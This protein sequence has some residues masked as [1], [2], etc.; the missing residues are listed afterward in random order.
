MSVK[1]IVKV[2]ALAA[3][4]ISSL[5]FSVLNDG[6]QEALRA[7]N[8]GSKLAN[9]DPKAAIDTLL[10]AMSIAE[11]LDS[12]GLDIIEKVTNKLPGLYYNVAVKSFKADNYAQA[13]TELLEAKKV[14]K[15]YNDE[16][17]SESVDKTLYAAYYKQGSEQFKA[18]DFAGAL[19]NFD[20]SLAIK[21]DYLTAMFYKGRAHKELKQYDQMLVTLDKTIELGGTDEKN[22]KVVEGAKTQAAKGLKEQSKAAAKAGNTNA[23]ISYLEKALTYISSSAEDAEEK[24]SCYFEMGGIY[25]KAGQKSKACEAYKKA[26]VGKFKEN[27]DYKVNIELKCGQ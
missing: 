23:A 22:A 2:F 20:N 24:A 5:N 15:K 8:A 18:K 27:A 25:E 11:K 16:K 21:G 17:T 1:Q 7:Y 9:E 6:R 26:A 13:I 3:I 12:N 19:I 10:L 14:A 4:V